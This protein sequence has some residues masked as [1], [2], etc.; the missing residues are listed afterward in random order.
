MFYKHT[1]LVFK[2]LNNHFAV[3]VQQLKA[4]NAQELMRSESLE[5][6]GLV[7]VG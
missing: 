4:G 1:S 6:G 7:V 5:H 3:S 2:H